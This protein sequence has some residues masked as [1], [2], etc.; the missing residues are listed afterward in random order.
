MSIDS[1]AGISLNEIT[2]NKY[3]TFGTFPK[4]NRKSYKEENRYH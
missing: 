4:S 3:Y 2:K 1:E